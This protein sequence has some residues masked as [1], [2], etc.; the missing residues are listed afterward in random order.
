MTRSEPYICTAPRCGRGFAT[1][2]R[3][4]TD[5][6]RR[7]NNECRIVASDAPFEA[8]RR[9]AAVSG[10]VDGAPVVPTAT[11]QPIAEAAVALERYLIPEARLVFDERVYTVSG[12]TILGRQGD[13]AAHEFAHD[14]TV[15]RRHARVVC[16][17]ARWYL[18]NVSEKGN[19]L[20]LDG[21]IVPYPESRPLRSGVHQIRLGPRFALRLE[22]R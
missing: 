7:V 1:K 4:P 14:T 13:L 22:I 8:E 18:E 3:R 20:D 6:D 15:S 19:G 16:R 12:D 10:T 11:G 21:E 9:V 17:N 2:V 5:C